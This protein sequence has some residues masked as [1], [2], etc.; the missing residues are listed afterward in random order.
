[1]VMPGNHS[2]ALVHYLAGR[3]PGRIGWLISPPIQ[4]TKLR[5]WMP[6]ALDNGAFAAWQK[7]RPFPEEAWRELI[8]HVRLR[9]LTPLWVL[10]P[11]VVADRAGTIQSWHRWEPE[12]RRLGWP[13]AF[14][15]QDEMSASD[16]PASADV[17]F[18]GGSTKWKWRTVAYWA[19]HFGRVHVGRVNEVERVELCE[20]LGVESVDGTGWFRA[21]EEGR[22]ARALRRWI[23]QGGSEPHPELSFAGGTAT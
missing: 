14:A 11:D 17:V 20:R 13:L 6:F 21:T 23:E 9:Q 4:S 8:E 18:V 15:V 2:G 7:K 12:L 1:M 22:Q 3:Y 19:K 16:V 5:D 10:V